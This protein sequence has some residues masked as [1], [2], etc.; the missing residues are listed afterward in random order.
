MCG[1]RI[2]ATKDIRLATLR[3]LVK[4][5][6]NFYRLSASHAFESIVRSTQLVMGASVGNRPSENLL[7]AHSITSQEGKDA[8]YL[9][10]NVE[11]DNDDNESSIESIVPSNNIPN[12][13]SENSQNLTV[14][15]IKGNVIFPSDEFFAGTMK[16]DLD[17]ALIE[18]N[19]KQYKRPNA[20]IAV[21]EPARPIFLSRAATCHPGE[22]R[23]IVVISSALNP[24]RGIL[25]PGKSQTTFLHVRF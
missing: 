14:E 17:W 24:R 7:S 6:S 16:A 20:Y 25:L 5:Q 1:S 15:I 23:D 4:I 8:Y 3:Y 12:F 13:R 2:A 21:T 11:Y 22:Q 18:I 10:D 19:E 9:V